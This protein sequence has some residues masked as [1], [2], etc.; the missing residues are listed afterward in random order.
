M[1]FILELLIDS[2]VGIGKMIVGILTLPIGILAVLVFCYLCLI[3]YA[4]L[5]KFYNLILDFIEDIK[6]K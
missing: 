3:I 5:D 6:R 4:G 1:Q 2:L